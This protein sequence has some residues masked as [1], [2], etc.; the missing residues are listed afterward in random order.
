MLICISPIPLPGVQSDTGSGWESPIKQSGI[1]GWI[2]LG[3]HWIGN[4]VLLQLA[5]EC[6]LADAQEFGGF[7]FVA[8]EYTDCGQDGLSLQ[9]SDR[10]HHWARSH[11]LFLALRGRFTEW[12]KHR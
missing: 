11:S 3:T 10:C 8:V 9:F 1:V 5:V 12:I 2:H 4:A 6:G 7:Q